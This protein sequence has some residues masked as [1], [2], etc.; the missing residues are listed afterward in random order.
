MDSS[1]Q[2]VGFLELLESYK[3]DMGG[4]GGAWGGRNQRCNESWRT[5]LR[6]ARCPERER[7]MV[8]LYTPTLSDWSFFWGKIAK[9]K[10]LIQTLSGME[11]TNQRMQRGTEHDNKLL[12]PLA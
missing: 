6:D 10:W 2:F 12:L 5:M 7:K 11:T 9:D 3:F 8:Y 1:R 4:R